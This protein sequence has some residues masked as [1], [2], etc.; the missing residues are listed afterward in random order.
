[1]K[2]IRIGVDVDG[3]LY[4]WSDTARWILH[5]AF[6]YNLGDSTSWHYLKSQVKPAHWDWLWRTGVEVYGLFRHGNLYPGSVEG[7][8][9]LSRLGD[10]V[11]ITMRPRNAMTDTLAWL[12]YH[13]LPVDELHVLDHGRKSSV[14]P[15]CD[16][17]IDDSPDVYEDL[18]ANTSGV[19]LL[20]D[21]PWNQDVPVRHK[22][23]WEPGGTRVSSWDEVIEQVRL[24]AWERCL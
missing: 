22:R 18:T 11:V 13:Q 16:V 4:R 21:R 1:M 15:H 3:V 20:W 9:E 5:H 7:M 19:V 14:Q 24:T 6:G 8:K 23:P 17:Y 10:I 12:S 2:R